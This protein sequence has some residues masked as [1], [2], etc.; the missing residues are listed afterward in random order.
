[1]MLIQ[2]EER[3]GPIDSED[4]R[5]TGRRSCTFQS[6]RQIRVILPSSVCIRQYIESLLNL[7]KPTGGV[8]RLVPVWMEL[9][10]EALVS[11]FDHLRRCL[12]MDL[13]NF[14]MSFGGH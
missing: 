5:R 10:R 12:G 2:R 13:Q 7:G 4:D 9:R 14:V 3:A 11:R 1:M 6:A 8:C